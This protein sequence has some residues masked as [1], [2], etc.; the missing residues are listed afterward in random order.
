MKY[1]TVAVYGEIIILAINNYYLPMLILV[2][3]FDTLTE[4]LRLKK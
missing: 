1:Y 4:V 2:T 3:F